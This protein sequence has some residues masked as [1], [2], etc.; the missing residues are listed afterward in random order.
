M[1]M[2]AAPNTQVIANQVRTWPTFFLY[3]ARTAK[4]NVT[5]EINRAKVFFDVFMDNIFSDI[6]T[7][8][9]ISDAQSHILEVQNSLREIYE[10][11]NKI[12]ED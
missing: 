6:F 11:L 8:S 10:E 1:P 5:E 9:K 7:Q 12:N 4:P 2:K 3:A